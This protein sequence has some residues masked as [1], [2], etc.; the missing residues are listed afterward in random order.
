MKWNVFRFN[1][2]AQKMEVYDIFDHESFKAYVEE[3]LKECETKED[4]AY[5]LINELRYYFWSKCEWEIEII[6]WMRRQKNGLKIDVF[7]QIMLNFDRFVDYVWGFKN[8]T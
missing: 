7:Q 2:N 8:E 1:C 4:F 6:D 5:Q 3:S